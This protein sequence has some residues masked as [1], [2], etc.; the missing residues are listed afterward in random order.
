MSPKEET[1]YT[2]KGEAVVASAHA[3]FIRATPRK[4][5]LVA[6]QIRNKT[7]AEA[8]EILQYLHRPSATPHVRRALLSAAKNAELVHPEP[9]TLLISELRVDGGPILKRIRPRAMGRAARI[10]KRTCHIH[11]FLT[12]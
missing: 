9:E 7:V 3:R 5:R 8:L 10:R 12:E 2:A 4:I 6:D 11:L 1:Q